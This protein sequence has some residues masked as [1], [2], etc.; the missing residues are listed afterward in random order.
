[1]Q[2][3]TVWKWQEKKQRGISCEY[4]TDL[5][6]RLLSTSMDAAITRNAVAEWADHREKKRRQ[7]TLEE[8][9]AIN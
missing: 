7:L 9:W 2:T 8:L 4:K 6:I 5:A 1:M 3:E